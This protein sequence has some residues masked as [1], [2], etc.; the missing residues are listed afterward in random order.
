VAEGA[1]VQNAQDTNAR[2]LGALI[3]GVRRAYPYVEAGQLDGVF[4]RH[5]TQLFKTVH[6][7]PFHVATQALMLIFQVRC[8]PPLLCE[9]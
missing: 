5:A 7:A 8:G 3:T 2:M 6:V 4:E 1:Q 9:P